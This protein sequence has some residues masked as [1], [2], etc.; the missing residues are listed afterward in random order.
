[1]VK[2]ACNSSPC[3]AEVGGLRVWGHS[4]LYSKILSQK[5]IQKPTKQQK[6]PKPTRKKEIGRGD[7]EQKYAAIGPKLISLGN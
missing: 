2:R 5:K 1:M 6:I 4:G 3:E 7:V